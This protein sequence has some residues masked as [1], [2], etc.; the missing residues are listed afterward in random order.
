MDESGAHLTQVPRCLCP[1]NRPLRANAACDRSLGRRGQE[2]VKES[3]RGILR[4]MQNVSRHRKRRLYP[5][6]DKFLKADSY[7]IANPHFFTRSRWDVFLH[8]LSSN[9]H[10]L[11][12]PKFQASFS[13]TNRLL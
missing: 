8:A 11:G 6:Y 2:R 10:V 13:Y 7:E 4:A 9:R 12:R 1:D 5:F 3:I